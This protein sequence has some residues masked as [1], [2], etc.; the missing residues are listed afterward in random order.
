MLKYFGVKVET[1]FT[2][3]ASTEEVVGLSLFRVR[4][5]VMNRVEKLSHNH[6][7][8]CYLILSMVRTC[9]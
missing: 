8:L 4:N 2:F 3:E 7:E 5:A 1:G 6:V 9:L